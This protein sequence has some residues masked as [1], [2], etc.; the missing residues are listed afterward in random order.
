M[1][2]TVKLLIV[3]LHQRLYLYVPKRTS[4]I[5]AVPM[6]P[7]FA[8]KTNWVVVTGAASSGKTTLVNRLA[9]FLEAE[10]YPE[11]ARDYYES[12][13]HEEGSSEEIWDDV[14]SSIMPIHRLRVQLEESLKLDSLVL[15]DTAIP[16]T[17]PYSLIHDEEIHGVHDDCYRFEYYKKV[18]LLEQLGLER[19]NIR[20]PDRSERDKIELMKKIIYSYLG[21]EVIFVPKMSIDKRV[22]FV[23]SHIM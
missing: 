22:K 8:S 10:F 5:F 23:A 17:L 2:F 9:P 11:P 12:K 6:N 1:P 16:D 4:K 15:L 3:K 20:K 18:F 21:Y 14:K 19:D 7:D 13:R